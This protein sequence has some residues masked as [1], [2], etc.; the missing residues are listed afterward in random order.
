MK[1]KIYRI[2]VL[3]PLLLSV[4]V[5]TGCKVMMFS[6][7][8]K[9]KEYIIEDC[10]KVGLHGKVTI[11]NLKWTA[12]ESPTYHVSYIYSEKT[13]DG[14]TIKLDEVNTAIREN[15]PLD[16]NDST[17]FLDYK[18][19]F[20][21]QKSLKKV[22]EKIKNQLNKQSLGFSISS[23]SFEVTHFKFNEKEKILDSIASEN[24]KEGKKDF[25]G[26]YQI[27]YQTMIDEELVDMTIN[28]D[29]TESVELQ[30]IKNATEKLDAS[31][32]PNGKY[33][34]DYSTSKDGY[35]STSYSF[36]VKDGE[37]SIV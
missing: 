22:G 23:L 13:H 14:Q 25:A 18:E 2:L 35:Y 19:V 34:F 31:D 20:V 21:K 26:Y 1:K 37:V 12:L 36:T 27:P 29:G 28:I 33:K 4:L 7:Y 10:N 3:I 9:V 6:D 17:L 15:N 5:L 16:S 32:L 11:T 8:K 30:D 24:R